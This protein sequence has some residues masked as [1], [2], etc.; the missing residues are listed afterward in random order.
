M[1]RISIIVPLLN[2]I[3]IKE[4]MAADKAGILVESAASLRSKSLSWVLSNRRRSSV[5]TDR[6]TL[7]KIEDGNVS[8]SRYHEEEETG[9]LRIIISGND[10]SSEDA[11]TAIGSILR[12]QLRASAKIETVE[13]QDILKAMQKEGLVEA[14]D[15]PTLFAFAR[16]GVQSGKRGELNYSSISRRSWKGEIS[17][18]KQR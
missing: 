8:R 2:D 7:L 11:A 17:H 9:H 10:R 5:V 16:G 13:F 4:T 12:D 6:G 14:F 18:Q 3:S 1:S 15:L